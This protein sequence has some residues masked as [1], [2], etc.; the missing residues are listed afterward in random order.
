MSK[1]LR[2]AIL[3]TL[4]LIIRAEENKEE[5]KPKE[6][7]IDN[8]KEQTIKESE[9]DVNIQTGGDEMNAPDEGMVYEENHQEE[10]K[11]LMIIR[12]TNAKH[13]IEDVNDGIRVLLFVENNKKILLDKSQGE[14]L[15]R[16]KLIEM[17]R[18]NREQEEV[19]ET[20]MYFTS[21]RFLRN[22]CVEMQIDQKENEVVYLTKYQSYPISYNDPVLEMKV[23]DKLVQTLEEVEDINHLHEMIENKEGINTILFNIDDENREEQMRRAKKL[24]EKCIHECYEPYLYVYLKNKDAFLENEENKGKAFLVRN[25]GTIPTP[26]KLKS[27]GKMGL[28]KTMKFLNNEGLPEMLENSNEN[29]FRIYQ[30]DLKAMVVLALNTDNETQK[31]MLMKEFEQAAKRHRES[32]KDYKDRYSFVYSDMHEGDPYYNDMLLEVTGKIAKESALFIFSKGN[33]DISFRNLEFEENYNDVRRF[34]QDIPNE[35]ERVKELRKRNE[36]KEEL[37]LVEKVM[38]D[39]GN[40]YEKEWLLLNGILKMT[41]SEEADTN[42]I[43]TR[44]I[45]GFISAND[46]IKVNNLYFKSEE[47]DREYNDANLTNGIVKVTGKNF[48][49]LV[50]GVE[51][52]E[53]IP[54]EREHSFI[55]LVCR[56]AE[57][58]LEKDCKRVADLLN[59]LRG[60]FPHQHADIRIGTFDTIHNDHPILE[61]FNIKSFPVLIFFGKKNKKGTGKIYR[62]AMV[63]KKLMNWL[64]RRLAYH[65]EGIIEMSESD[66][67][68]LLLL[69]AKSKK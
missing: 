17:L 14:G 21:C 50:Y 64:N 61:K 7:N 47:E 32:R 59:F 42:K 55:L 3:F 31:A 19:K 9:E 4:F 10:R 68:A 37:N 62:K 5:L 30:N 35:I 11:E 6:E 58:K 23:M 63:I 60:K 54:E 53:I 26:F 67:H 51:A 39:N 44:N 2:V 22:L 24:T 18:S 13:I 12:L 57:D 36:N 8:Q 1:S 33:H 45:L 38:L 49:R 20:A 16:K 27:E 56:N 28:L 15:A 41:E 25:K 46:A 52:D 34:M 69:M 29:Y 65:E 40:R 66:Y 48:S 43:N